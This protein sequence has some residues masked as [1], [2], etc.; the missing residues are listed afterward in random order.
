MFRISLILCF[1]VSGC[2]EEY[3]IPDVDLDKKSTCETFLGDYEIVFNDVA[4][5]LCCF[6][7][8]GGS[9]SCL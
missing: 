6:E 5:Y 2:V 1:V 8:E 3:D 7:Q 4:E 9:R